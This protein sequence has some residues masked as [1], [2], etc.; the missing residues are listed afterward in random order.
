MLPIVIYVCLQISMLPCV[1]YVCIYTYHICYPVFGMYVYI[2]MLPCVMC[3]VHMYVYLCYPLLYMCVYIYLCYPVNGMCYVHSAYVCMS[4]LP[5][6][7]YVCI[8]ISMLPC[9]WYAVLYMHLCYPSQ[10]CSPMLPM[11]RHLY[12]CGLGFAMHNTLAYIYVHKHMWCLWTKC[13]ETVMSYENRARNY[14]RGG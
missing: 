1:R 11:Y 6:V 12:F 5:I 13:N 3:T 14:V 9:E 10:L 2:P 4:I 7:I 8:H